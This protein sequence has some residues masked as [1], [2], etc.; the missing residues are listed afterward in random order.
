MTG[1]SLTKLGAV[2]VVA[3][4]LLMAGPVFGF[5]TLAAD[6]GVNVGTAATESALLAIDS[7]GETPD[8]QNDAVV[9]NITNNAN[10]R[11]DPLDAQAAIV[12]DTGNALAIS[13]GFDT[14]LDPGAT[15]G[16]ELTCSGGGEGNATVEVTADASGPTLSIQGVTYSHSFSYSCTGSGSG[17]TADAGGP[18]TTYE[19]ESVQLDGTGS[20]SSTGNI[21]DYTWTLVEGDGSLENAGSAEPTYVAPNDLSENTSVTVELSV[22]DNQGNTDTDEAAITVYEES[23]RSLTADFAYTRS[24]SENGNSKNVDLDGSPSIAP[25]GTIDTYEWDV[26]NDGT[27]DYTGETVSKADVP[28]GTDVTLTVTTESGETDSVT[29]VVE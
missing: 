5:S 22:T 16:L 1:G 20:A 4:V 13:N 24:G 12:E 25:D 3:G 10:E 9:I 18:Y 26:G 19:G 27:I 8:K 6:R 11:F 14:A 23:Y 2:L 21:K 28:S 29:K 15:T 17:P 7:T